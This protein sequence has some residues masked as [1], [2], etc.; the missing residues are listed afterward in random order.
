VGGGAWAEHV[1]EASGVPF[2]Y[3]TDT[4][5]TQWERPAELGGVGDGGNVPPGGAAGNSVGGQHWAGANGVH[6][7][8][9]GRLGDAPGTEGQLDLAAE[10]SAKLQHLAHGQTAA[11]TQ[12]KRQKR[13]AGKSSSQNNAPQ[14]RLNKDYLSM[15]REYT[16]S[17]PYR[18]LSGAQPCLVCGTRASELVLF[19]CA[20]KCL[21]TACAK[22][23]HFVESSRAK[24]EEGAWCFC[25][26]CNEEI[27]RILPHTG[28]E[29]ADYWTWVHEVKPVLPGGFRSR[30]SQSS[31]MLEHGSIPNL[32][33]LK[34]TQGRRGMKNS[35]TSAEVR[36]ATCCLS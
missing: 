27:K 34:K 15:A 10:I 17:E 1:D 9:V 3:N 11:H 26:L 2:Y 19:P 14:A 29:V 33:A 30:L 35:G 23:Q 20:H 32:D 28:T 22:S 6:G 8:A 21:C 36:S 16:Q 13:R 5:Q 4:G 31:Q 18:N 25:P 7:C 24:L 12:P